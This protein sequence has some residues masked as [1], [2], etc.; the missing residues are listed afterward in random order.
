[1]IATGLDSLLHDV[2]QLTG[3]RFGLLAHGASV[4]ADCVPAHLALAAAGVAPL[5]LFGPEHGYYGVEQ[6]MVAASS[7][8]HPWTGN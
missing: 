3:R 1:M 2:G 8:R 7:Q 4:T 6:D 5:R